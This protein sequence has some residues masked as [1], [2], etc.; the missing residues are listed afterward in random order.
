M[1]LQRA[2]RIGWVSSKELAAA[3]Y[4]ICVRRAQMLELCSYLRNR[5]EFR[6]ITPHVLEL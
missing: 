4:N 6:H 5:N 1:L 3:V 2:D